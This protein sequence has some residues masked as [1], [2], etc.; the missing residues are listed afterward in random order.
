MTVKKSAEDYPTSASMSDNGVEQSSSNRPSI[1]SYEEEEVYSN[2]HLHNV[3]KNILQQRCFEEISRNKAS[4]TSSRVQE[5]SSIA[6]NQT[7]IRD[8]IW[9]PLL[10]HRQ[11][12]AQ[13]ECIS[14]NSDSNSIKEKSIT[15]RSSTPSAIDSLRGMAAMQFRKEYAPVCKP[16]E[17]ISPSMSWSDEK[18]PTAIEKNDEVKLRKSDTTSEPKPWNDAESTQLYQYGISSNSHTVP[19]L[20]QQKIMEFCDESSTEEISTNPTPEDLDEDV[21]DE[22]VTVDEKDEPIS[23]N[24]NDNDSN[25][26][27]DKNLVKPPYSYIALITMSILQSPHKKLTLSGICEFIMNRFPYYREKF[28]AWQNSIRH[29][30]SLNDCFVKVPREPGNPGKGNYWT[31][32]PDAE[33][34]FDNGSFLRRRKR[35]KRQSRNP[36]RDH[37]IAAAV[38][39]VPV[40]YGRP[41]GMGLSG[42]QA[43]AFA[44]AF[45]PYSYLHQTMPPLLDH[46]QLASRQAA[47]IFGFG[48]PNTGSH[49]P[50]LNPTSAQNAI[51]QSIIPSSTTHCTPQSLPSLG[52]VIHPMYSSIFGSRNHS[53]TSSPPLESLKLNS[54]RGSSPREHSKSSGFSIDNLIGKKEDKIEPPLKRKSCGESENSQSKRRRNSNCSCSSNSSHDHAIQ[55]KKH[56]SRTESNRSSSD[57]DQVGG[58]SFVP[59]S[60]HRTSPGVSS[61]S[62]PIHENRRK[63]NGQYHSKAI[64]NFESNQ[65]KFMKNSMTSDDIVSQMRAHDNSSSALRGNFSTVSPD[66]G[67]IYNSLLNAA[68]VGRMAGLTGIHSNPILSGGPS[69]PGTFNTSPNPSLRPN[70]QLNSILSSN[71]QNFL[72]PVIGWPS[73]GPFM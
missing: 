24:I 55:S 30:L 9:N 59:P 71:A 52:N 6:E 44:A 53:S 70:A 61:G 22:E 20:A 65:S 17:Q 14:T 32:D 60:L 49:L 48:G 25:M 47:A 42:P 19:A 26:L 57:S 40:S 28:P 18:D 34:M 68:M 67:A 69:P 8:L 62:S 41:Y 5:E 13:K 29:N 63:N 38:N 45:N 39:G 72:K 4:E 43:A 7:N 46:S 64:Y 58:G 21:F 31:M 73:M 56:E 50:S 10:V 37:M 36:L 35:F 12:L 23:I 1:S 3:S 54:P 16:Y 66:Q 2:T 51:L 33:D 11:Y 15:I 27:D